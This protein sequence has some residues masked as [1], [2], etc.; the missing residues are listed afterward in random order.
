MRYRTAALLVLVALSISASGGVMPNMP[1]SAGGGDGGGSVEE[2][3]TYLAKGVNAPLLEKH[4]EG[5]VSALACM[6]VCGGEET[7]RGDNHRTRFE[8]S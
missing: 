1:A 5:I 2:W 3:A 8:E 6:C 7:G 4:F